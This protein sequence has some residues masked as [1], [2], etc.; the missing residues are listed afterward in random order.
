MVAPQILAAFVLLGGA[1]A[2]MAFVGGG[3][4]WTYHRLQGSSP[5]EL[6]TLGDPGGEVELAGTARVHD[7]TTRTPFT[8]T[9]SLVYEWKVQEYSPGPG[10]ESP[11]W[12]T[13]DS[14]SANHPFVLYDGTGTALVEAHGSSPHLQRTTE[15]EVG[16]GETPPGPIAEYIDAADAV[17]RE[18][19][20]T[21]RFEE[22][23]LDPGDEVHVL[24]PVRESGASFDLPG[25]VDAV[26]GVENP[27]KRGWTV[28]EDSLADLREQI[29]SD[30]VQFIVSNADEA[31]AEKHLRSMGALWFGLGVFFVALPFVFLLFG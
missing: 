28:G 12:L 29:G 30:T 31:G 27:G 26:V 17:D 3:Y 23:R 11:S 7:E 24:G 20:R 19:D 8:D 4:L 5:V 18:F 14:G 22:R 15:V 16:P 10:S 1:G 6:R 2:L 13:Q 9:E 21:H 25:G